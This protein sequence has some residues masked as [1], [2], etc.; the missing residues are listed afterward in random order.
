MD[1]APQTADGLT[2]FYSARLGPYN[3]ETAGRSLQQQLGVLRTVS[4][5]DD[6]SVRLIYQIST[7]LQTSGYL[8][9]FFDVIGVTES[10][11]EAV[12]E[13]L[14][15]GVGQQLATAFRG[16]WDVS[17]GPETGT[18]KYSSVAELRLVGDAIPRI[19]ED[20]ATLVDYLRTLAGPVTVQMTCRRGRE[21]R[22]GLAEEPPSILSLSHLLPF[23]ELSGFFFSFERDAAAF[24]E[25]AH[26]EEIAGGANL[27]LLVHVGSAEPLPDS[28]L[29]AVGQWLFHAMPFE[30]VRGAAAR[31]QLSA[32]SAPPDGPSLTPSEI[33]RV[34]HPPYGQM[35]AR[36][37]DRQRSTSIPLPV[38]AL[39][40]EGLL[41]GRAR[42]EGT[43]QDRWVDVR[44]DSAARLR[45]FYVVGPT[46]S[47]KT[48]L[49]KNLARQD[50]VEHRG[51]AV[52]DPHGD[53]VDY[54]VKHTHGRDDEVLLL[55]FGDPE[56]LPV[57]NP[58]DLDVESPDEQ[59][60]AIENFIS[61]MVRQSHHTFYG[62]R[63]ESM[64]RLVLASTTNQN[65]PFQ[66]SSVLDVGTILRNEDTK[67]WLQALLKNE[68]GLSERWRT[69]DKQ[70]GYDFAG[71]A[72]L[73]TG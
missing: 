26:R 52:I 56:F 3:A 25:R 47:G 28:V 11:D 41:L 30:I 70:G 19:R 45:H 23:A 21:R 42:I 34:F 62:P 35:E 66:P 71:A 63:F 36:G 1:S 14:R 49:L 29:R 67:R 38:T 59:N 72:R 33:L 40:T 24:L 54:L 58:L 73:G 12:L 48:N 8:A 7:A 50:I 10:T 55:D 51:L 57:L 68:P 39:S 31:E 32:R 64:V 17:S 22:S 53:L 15:E 20:W 65:Y 27:S 18:L 37:L 44:M 60:L 16:S 43:R 46:G 69:F 13:D 2:T 6:E 61:L 5:A 9:P 4:A